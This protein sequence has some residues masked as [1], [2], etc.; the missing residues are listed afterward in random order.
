M[1]RFWS[2]VRKTP[3]CWVWIAATRKRSGHGIFW[4]KGASREAHLVSLDL[5]GITI[6]KGKMACHKC[7]N[8][9]CVRPDH[10]Y[11]GTAKSNYDDMVSVGRNKMPADHQRAR[12]EAN[13]QSV[14]TAQRV[15]G[16]K[17]LLIDGNS[18]NSVARMYAVDPSTISRIKSG[19]RW[20]EVKAASSH[21]SSV[22]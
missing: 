18:I 15:S 13:G 4:Y 12:G 21:F 6:P 10:I 20:K 11:A 17:L 9:A 19:E 16:I 3:S 8:A 1:K 2:K 14:L 7:N 5:H 22:G